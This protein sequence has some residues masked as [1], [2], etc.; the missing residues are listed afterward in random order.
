MELYIARVLRPDDHSPNL[1]PRLFALTAG[2]RLHLAPHVHGTYT[3]APVGDEDTVVFLAT[4]TGEAPHNAMIA[5]LLE[6]GHRGPILSAVC[7]RYRIDL[8]Y[9]AVHRELE[10]RFAKYRYVTLTTREPENVD[11]RR[12]DFVGK[13]YLQNYLRSGRLEE[14]AGAALDPDRTHVY[15]CGN[16]EMIGLPPPA[17]PGLESPPPAGGMVELLTSRGLRL[18]HPHQPGQIH[19]ERFW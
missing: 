2:S 6:R 17:G 14:D 7:V 13:Q 10:R 16:P 11:A 15:L 18:D 5:E 19:C 9:L 4:G 3:L 1:T 8:A 12:A